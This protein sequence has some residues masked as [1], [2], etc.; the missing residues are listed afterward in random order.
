MGLWGWVGARA[1]GPAVPLMK[2]LRVCCMVFVEHRRTCLCLCCSLTADRLRTGDAVAGRTL[3][4]FSP[5]NPAHI[6]EC[7]LSRMTSTSASACQAAGPGACAAVAWVM[8]KSLPAPVCCCLCYILMLPPRH[9]HWIQINQGSVCTVKQPTEGGARCK[10]ENTAFVWM[11][12]CFCRV[13]CVC[14]A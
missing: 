7:T 6:W 12:C 13:V 4:G 9:L 2:P 5:H 1:T 14:A 11:C 3:P 10:A 8:A